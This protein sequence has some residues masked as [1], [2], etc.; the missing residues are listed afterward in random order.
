MIAP[1]YNLFKMAA[2]KN[3]R[4]RDVIGHQGGGARKVKWIDVAKC[5]NLEVDGK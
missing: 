1:P 5:C 3:S 4:K 2:N